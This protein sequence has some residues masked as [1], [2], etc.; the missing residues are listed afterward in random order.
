MTSSICKGNHSVTNVTRWETDR[1]LMFT[2]SGSK[3]KKMFESTTVI[4]MHRWI[5]MAKGCLSRPVVLT[6]H[7]IWSARLLILPCQMVRGCLHFVCRV[8]WP[9]ISWRF[10]LVGWGGGW[11]SGGGGS[12]YPI[13]KIIYHKYSVSLSF[14]CLFFFFFFSNI[15]KLFLDKYPVFQYKCQ[16]SQN[17]VH[18]SIIVLLEKI[19]CLV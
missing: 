2:S 13:P 9:G 18:T 1:V 19:N 14:F 15:P 17:R 7:R 5:A 3:C 8:F 4:C 12:Q 11:V 6:Q 16:I 10:V